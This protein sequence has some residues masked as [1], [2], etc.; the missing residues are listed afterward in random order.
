MK[1]FFLNM[2]LICSM[3]IAA[4]T[5]VPAFFGDNIVLQQNQEVSI[6][7]Y[8]DSTLIQKMIISEFLMAVKINKR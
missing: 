8:L 3:A 4:Q 6:W 1:N 5:K 2:A 7:S